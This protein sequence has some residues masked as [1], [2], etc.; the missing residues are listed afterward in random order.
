MHGLG[1]SLFALVYGREPTLPTDV[2]YGS[3]KAEEIDVSE[4]H[5]RTTAR[6]RK[7]YQLALESNFGRFPSQGSLRRKIKYCDVSAG[8]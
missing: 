1:F 3:R 8:R 4:Y 5:L 7:S 6:L 2:L